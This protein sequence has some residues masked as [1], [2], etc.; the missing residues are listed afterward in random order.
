MQDLTKGS[1]GRHVLSLAAF[2]A[3]STAF[4]TLYFLADL[5]F[6]GWLGKQAIAGVALGGNLTML[7]LALTQSLGVGATALISQSLGQKDRD[8][9]VLLLNQ[10]T[11][12]S[13]LAALAFGV[14]A[15]VLRGSY[16][17]AVAAD[18]PTAAFGVQYLNWFIPALCLQFPMVSMGAALRAQG[19]TKTPAT[20]QMLSTL[21]N[22]VF[23]PVFMFGWGTG[24]PL[25]VAGAG[26]ASFVAL[27]VGCCLLV[28]HF[29]RAPGAMRFSAHQARP[30]P[31]LWRQVLGIGLPAGGEFALVTVYMVLVYVLIRPFGTDAQAAFG[32]S[33]RI[34][35]ALFL[36]ALAIAF[37]AAPVVGQNYGARLALRVRETFLVAGG[38]CAAVMI[39]LTL[40]CQAAP[41]SL[42]RLFNDDVAVVAMGAE[43]LRI[44][45]CSFLAS[46]LVFVSSSIFQGLGNTWPPLITSTARLLAFAVPA[47]WLSQQSGFE[48]R[49]VWYLS[50]LSVTLQV[51]ANLFLL[52]REFVR[53]LLPVETLPV[54]TAASA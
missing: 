13:T 32:I 48:L 17:R 31:D 43:Y 34:M 50:A 26:L 3:L 14:T 52:R 7:V 24:R 19:D 41:Q 1:I 4:Q 20:I 54:P 2:V 46:G 28:R 9:A 38:M 18:L 47:F 15:Y 16:C 45:S 49:H 25:G 5:Y 30:R 10:T 11:L 6:V 40:L 51:V 44:V 35:Q 22:I 36:P 42:V 12:L 8:R 37:A 33:G 53:R 21:L 29:L 23:A 39:A 27:A